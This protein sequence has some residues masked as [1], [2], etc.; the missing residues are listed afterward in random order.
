M[1]CVTDVAEMANLPSRNEQ[2][3]TLKSILM[4]FEPALIATEQ[5]RKR[6]NGRPRAALLQRE[7]GEERSGWK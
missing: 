4:S 1:A 5:E 3:T 7:S 6:N 2:L